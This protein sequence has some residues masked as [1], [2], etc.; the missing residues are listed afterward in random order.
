VYTDDCQAVYDKALAFGGCTSQMAPQV[1]TEWN[2]T[3]AF[4]ADPD[5]YSI[6]IVQRH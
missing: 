6:E 3:V 2:C 1:L 4:V 5:G